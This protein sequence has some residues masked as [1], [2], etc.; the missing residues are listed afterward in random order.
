MAKVH[1]KFSRALIDAEKSDIDVQ[2]EDIEQVLKFL[3]RNYG[4]RFNEQYFDKNRRPA[5]F[6]NIYVNGTEIRVLNGVHTA[7]KDNDEIVMFP[8]V[9]GG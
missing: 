6:I 9:K 4:E 2:A 5:S 3:S 1:V 7:L 8:A